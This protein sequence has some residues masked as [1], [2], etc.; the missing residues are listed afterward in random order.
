MANHLIVC[1]TTGVSLDRKQCHH[2]NISLTKTTL[3]H[4]HPHWEH[5]ISHFLNVNGIGGG[6]GCMAAHNFLP[7]GTTTIPSPHNKSHNKCAKDHHSCPFLLLPPSCL[8]RERRTYYQTRT[9]NTENLMQTISSQKK[10]MGNLL[11]C[12]R[13]FFPHPV[14]NA[15]SPIPL[16]TSVS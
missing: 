8:A 12:G 14:P 7:L 4:P 9:K 2:I 10:K 5:T 13:A 3:T 1:N 16:P 11:F 6:W 15:H